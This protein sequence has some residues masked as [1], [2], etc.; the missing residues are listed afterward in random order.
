MSFL[1]DNR[2]SGSFCSLNGQGIFT[3]DL[4]GLATVMVLV[5]D[6]FGS[7]LG[8]TAI[9]YGLFRVTVSYKHLLVY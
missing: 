6:V 3:E 1:L 9:I 4:A 5:S 7:R 2:F 8:G